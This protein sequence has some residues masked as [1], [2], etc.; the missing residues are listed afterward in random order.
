M[1]FN[2]IG[3][4]TEALAALSKKEAVLTEADKKT[5]LQAIDQLHTVDTLHA[6]LKKEKEDRKTDKANYD[7]QRKQDHI[8][9]NLRNLVSSLQTNYDELNPD[10]KLMSIKNVINQAMQ[11]KNLEFSF[12]ESGE[13]QLINKDGTKAY[14][15]NHTLITPESF[16]ESVLAQNKIL[17]VAVQTNADDASGKAGPQPDLHNGTKQTNVTGNNELVQQL[18]KKTREAYQAAD[19]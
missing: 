7:A 19:Q 18:N 9:F 13:M 8:D 1:D 5:I 10:V 14:G 2:N 15:A 3:N 17:K 16:V 4:L 6:D 12:S 11:L